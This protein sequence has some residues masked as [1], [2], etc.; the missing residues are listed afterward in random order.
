MPEN[1]TT[2]SKLSRFVASRQRAA[3]DPAAGHY[4]TH[5]F[6]SVSVIVTVFMLGLGLGNPAAGSQRPPECVDEAFDTSEVAAAEWHGTCHTK[7]QE[8]GPRER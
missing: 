4:S 2:I 6:G 1:A 7:A 8:L 5:A 3:A